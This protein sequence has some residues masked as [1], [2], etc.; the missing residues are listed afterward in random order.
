MNKED[1]ELSMIDF[2]SKTGISSSSR[3]SHYCG[4]DRYE[5]ILC[6]IERPESLEG[7][8]YD[9]A[10]NCFRHCLNK[11]LESSFL[12]FSKFVEVTKI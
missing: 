10:M 2:F 4:I 3:C 11:N 7:M 8:N 6:E 5:K 12:G 1:I 9:M